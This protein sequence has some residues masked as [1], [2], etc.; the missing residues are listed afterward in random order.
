MLWL[1]T[2]RPTECVSPIPSH[3]IGD[4]GSKSPSRLVRSFFLSFGLY[5]PRR[6]SD[7]SIFPADSALHSVAGW[8]QTPSTLSAPAPA[9]FPFPL[10]LG[11]DRSERRKMAAAAR[12]RALSLSLSLSLSIIAGQSRKSR[13]SLRAETRLHSL[14]LCSLRGRVSLGPWDTSTHRGVVD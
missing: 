3:R 4:R 2:S 13:F 12:T 6:G 10:S 9:R 7:T 1:G 5:P 11:V 14:V 8:L